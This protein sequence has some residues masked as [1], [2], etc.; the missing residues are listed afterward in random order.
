MENNYLENYHKMYV[1]GPTTYNPSHCGHARTYIVV[2]LIVRTMNYYLGINTHLVMNITDIDN[3]I[4]NEGLKTNTHWKEIAK[5]Y[6]KSF[7]DSMRKLNVRLP[8]TIIRVTDTIP[9]IISYIQ[10][11]IDNGFAYVSNGSVYFD[12]E[13]YVKAGYKLDNLID[14]DDETL[15]ISEISSVILLQKKNKKDFVLWKNRSENDVHFDAEFT[16]GGEKLKSKGLVGWHIECSAMIHETLGPNINTHLGGIDLKFPHH[17]NER[18]Q[19]HAFYH[20][21]FLNAE[22]QWSDTMIHI[23][24]LCIKGLK[25]SKSLK[26][27]TTIDQALEETSSNQFRWLFMMH[28]IQEPMDFSEETLSKAK[29]FESA[30][31]NFFNKVS[32][33]PFSNK[34]VLYK[35]KEFVLDSYFTKSKTLIQDSLKDFSF[36]SVVLK[37]SKLLNKTNAYVETDFPNEPLVEKITSWLKHTLTI[38]GFGYGQKTDFSS[39]EIMDV[40]VENRSLIRKLIRENTLSKD[41]KQK[42]FYILDKERNID[43]P[44]IGINLQDTKDSSSWHFV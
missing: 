28:K 42:L 9:Q 20:P 21:M 12:S 27:F 16:Y 37:I 1:C 22:K 25:M 33:Y 32:N 11:I 19:A 8:D 14:N 2:D 36:D 3:K 4:I 30:L 44:A 31:V 34:N 43:L 17:Y 35:E 5:K 7:F 6:E 10:K 40:L 39:K 18:L 38:L 24:H 13:A 15:Y 29:I 26:N 41:L 23:G